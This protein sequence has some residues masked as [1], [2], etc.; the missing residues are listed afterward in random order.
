LYS[1]QPDEFTAEY[2]NIPFATDAVGVP[3]PVTSKRMPQQRR[4]QPR[5]TNVSATM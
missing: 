5:A 2:A 3:K 4:V 1:S